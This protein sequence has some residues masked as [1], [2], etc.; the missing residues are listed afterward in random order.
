MH[1]HYLLFITIIAALAGLLFGYDTGVINGTQYY[2]SKFFELS[3]A[4]KGWV[5]GSALLGC[6]V[7]AAASGKISSIIGRKNSLILSAVLFVVSAL[8]SGLP[9]FMPQSVTLL[10][11]FRIIGGIGIGI[12]SMN[13]PTYISEISPAPIRG[14]MVTYYQLAVVT[15]FFS[16]F[17]V[18]YLI[19]E[20]NSLE[21]NTS[22][23]WRVMFWT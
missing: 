12:A 4:V 7:G 22:Y 10:V 16:V 14:K 17:L 13:A 23:G 5:V 6:L 2:F 21:Y 20:G 19:G 15:G 9:S 18:T 8:G 1:K 3:P 11:I